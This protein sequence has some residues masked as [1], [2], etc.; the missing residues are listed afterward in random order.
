MFSFV[1]PV[2]LNVYFLVPV[3]HISILDHQL[4][5]V[6]VGFVRCVVATFV[7]IA[8]FSSRFSTIFDVILL[9]P[10]SGHECQIRLTQSFPVA[11]TCNGA[12]GGDG[13]VIKQD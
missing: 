4:V 1:V 6:Y 10:S 11:V 5:H 13:T 12:P 3:L 9:P 8:L 7:Q 2:S